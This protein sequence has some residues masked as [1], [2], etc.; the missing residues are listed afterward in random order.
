MTYKGV[1][2]SIFMISMM[3]IFGYVMVDA[4]EKAHEEI[5]KIYHGNVDS[6]RVG[7]FDGEMYCSNITETHYDSYSE[8]QSTVEAFGYQMKAFAYIFMFFVWALGM[9][10]LYHHEFDNEVD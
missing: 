2:W 10:Y 4:H 9:V 5:C 7:L 6:V 8:S 1:L 3:L